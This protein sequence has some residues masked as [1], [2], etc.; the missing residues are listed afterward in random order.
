M[1][2]APAGRVPV[3]RAGRASCSA[4]GDA[5][6]AGRTGW[7]GTPGASPKLGKGRVKGGVLLSGP[8]LRRNK[9]CAGEHTAPFAPGDAAAAGRTGWYGTPG[10]SPKLGKRRVKGGV[11]LSGPPLTRNKPCAR[12]RG[13]SVCI[14][15]G[16]TA[17]DWLR[18]QPVCRRPSARVRVSPSA[19]CRLGPRGGPVPLGR[20]HAGGLATSATGVSQ[21]C[22]RERREPSAPCRLGPRG[23]GRLSRGR[24][25]G[26]GRALRRR[27]GNPRHRDAG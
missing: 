12:V 27:G 11:L 24:H 17:G 20:D 9:P 10:A 26:G 21:P 7:Y 4:P 15:G 13:G 5:A 1:R 25:Q 14:P 19:P 18:P 8:P 23:G 2:G 22:A 6:A 3:A 16:T